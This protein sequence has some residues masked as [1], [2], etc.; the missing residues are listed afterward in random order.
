MFEASPTTP[1][2]P[3][4]KVDLAW[5]RTETGEAAAVRT[6]LLAL[7]EGPR[8]V[9]FAYEPEALRVLARAH[10]LEND[11][12]RG[13]GGPSAEPSLVLAGLVTGPTSSA[14]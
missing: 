7:T 14:A 9:P 1:L 6:E 11:P 5:A 8:A 3:V 2:G 4:I 10:E 13:A 12:G